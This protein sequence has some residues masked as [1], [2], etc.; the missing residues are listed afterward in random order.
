M[1]SVL[2]W[3]CSS[4]GAAPSQLIAVKQLVGLPAWGSCGESASKDRPRPRADAVSIPSVLDGL[5]RTREAGSWVSGTLT[6]SLTAM[7]CVVSM[8]QGLRSTG[9]ITNV[10]SREPLHLGALPDGAVVRGLD[11]AVMRTFYPVAFALIYNLSCLRGRQ[12]RSWASTK[13]AST[14]F[15]TLFLA[16]LFVYALLDTTFFRQSD[17]ISGCASPLEGSATALLN[18]LVHLGAAALL[19]CYS[20]QITQLRCLSSKNPRCVSPSSAPSWI[21]G[22]A[23]AYIAR[24]S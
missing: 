10:V 8:A 15:E 14:V 24:V 9:G 4:V 3:Q 12:H 6:E 21:L 22:P 17:R 23:R 20:Q 11:G 13:N 19:L 16:R 1:P 5:Q 2:L 7:I 18:F